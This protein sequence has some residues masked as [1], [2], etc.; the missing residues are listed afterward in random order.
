MLLDNQEVVIDNSKEIRL[1][2]ENPYITL[3]DSYT[4]D[5]SVPL[6]I[7]KNRVFFGNVQRI[8]RK[9]EYKEFACCLYY[10]NSLLLEGIA[11]I[12]QSTDTEV[13]IQLAS[14]V[15]ALKMSSEQEGF[16]IDSIIKEKEGRA[17]E[18]FYP[19]CLDYGTTKGDNHTGY[20][21]PFLDN[22]NS[23]VLNLLDGD[24]LAGR[25]AHYISDCPK[26]LDVATLISAEL[27]F[28]LDMS[29]LPPACNN[30]YIVS[31]AQGN[32]GKKLPHWTV[33]EFFKQFQNFFGCTF[34]NIGNNSLR[35]VSLNDFT[36][37]AFTT[38]K[39]LKEFH[40]EYSEDDEADGIIMRNV[41][42]EMENSDYEIVD[43]EILDQA[44]YT[45]EYSD[46]GA[47]VNAFLAETDIRMHKIYMVKGRKYIC[48][49]FSNGL[50]AL[51]RVAPFNPLRRFEN[52][53]SVVLKIAPAFMENVECTIFASHDL[54]VSSYDFKFY[55]ILPSVSNP[56]GL[57]NI[58]GMGADGNP[59]LQ[60]LIEGSESMVTNDQ[61]S[62]IMNVVFMDGTVETVTATSS[63]YGGH[64]FIF[65]IHLSFTDCDFKKQTN[66]NRKKWS[67]S[68]NELKDFDFYLGQLHKLDFKI[69][70]KV[71][72]VFKFLS[73]II[74]E[75]TNIFII[76][77]KI[78][79]CEKIEATI[80]DGKLDKLMT[81]YFYEM[82]L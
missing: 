81:G 71:K 2:K 1:Y 4:F 77:G 38:I 26:L 75:A 13:K 61:K 27:G 12:L 73:D 17:E 5:V 47:L 53:E 35:L 14:G 45:S 19:L 44:K 56:F 59:T 82:L 36:K 22:S 29:I 10:D 67:F 8:E 3:S 46:A 54:L 78:Y 9:K 72:H 79:A 21:I 58:W 60:D 52:T 57:T 24:S 51:Q 16:Y 68:L 80:R 55:A 48:K 42:F 7:L 20:G 76:Y 64:S 63:S 66:S 39:P 28:N 30:I 41:E 6:S 15:S 62:D 33:K 25:M 74:P 40:V 23:A 70:N 69:N 34:V 18:T 49:K 32:M 65:P 37:N 31:G 50:Y 11:R 43:D